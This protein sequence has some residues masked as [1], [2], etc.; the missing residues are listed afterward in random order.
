M[1]NSNDLAS[2]L[3]NAL[4]QSTAGNG[5]NNSTSTIS[6]TTSSI[7]NNANCNNNS[8]GINIQRS[9]NQNQLLQQK[10]SSIASSLPDHYGTFDP[11]HFGSTQQQQ[12][13]N[14]DQMN[15][16]PGPIARPRSYSTSNSNTNMSSNILP[17]ES[18]LSNYFKMQASSEDKPLGM[19]GPVSLRKVSTPSSLFGGTSS[20]LF[21]GLSSNTSHLNNSMSLFG[22]PGYPTTAD[23]V[24]SVVGSAL[25]DLNL[26]DIHLEASLEKELGPTGGNGG[27]DSDNNCLL[28]RSPASSNLLGSAPVNIPGRFLFSCILL[29]LIKNFY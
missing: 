11:N 29:I 2:I 9:N 25:E 7:I 27:S 10:S 13:F 15:S 19:N 23:T 8:S 21:S 4:P 24:E 3:S 1:D 22:A 20:P 6:S 12:I 28:G 26:D 14:C 5:I 17:S 16:G 18:L